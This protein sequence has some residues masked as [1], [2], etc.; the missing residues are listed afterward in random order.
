MLPQP[1][2]AGRGIEEG[3]GDRRHGFEQGA[4]V[5]TISNTISAV[6]ATC[7]PKGDVDRQE[8]G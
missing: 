4:E 5:S 3:D 2:R 8:T 7:A 1:A 6:A